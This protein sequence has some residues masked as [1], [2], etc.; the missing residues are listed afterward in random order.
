MKR[1]KF[2]VK[3]TDNLG[4]DIN[5]GDHVGYIYGHDDHYR[6]HSGIVIKL[7]DRTV[8]IKPDDDFKSDARHSE[9]YYEWKEKYYGP[10]KRSKYDSL[11]LSPYGRTV[12]LN[13]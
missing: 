11:Y 2:N 8:W 10:Q 3:G 12:K 13:Y 5:V 9:K 7:C 4:N 1:H 6:I